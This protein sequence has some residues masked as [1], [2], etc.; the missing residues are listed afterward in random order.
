M[1]IWCWVTKYVQLHPTPQLDICYGVHF[2]ITDNPAY[3]H[4]DSLRYRKRHVSPWV[5]VLWILL[6]DPIDL[7][8][9]TNVCATFYVKEE[10]LYND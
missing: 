10:L 2:V 5:L 1:E 6:K 7:T 9:Y 3:C 8:R 4:N